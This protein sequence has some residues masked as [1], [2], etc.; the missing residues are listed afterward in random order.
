MLSSECSMGC[1]VSDIKSCFLC[2][3][4][5]DPDNEWESNP[6]NTC[7]SC[8]TDHAMYTGQE[9]KDLLNA[10]LCSGIIGFEDI[11]EA[12]HGI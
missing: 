4:Y 6:D 5:E 3:S 8:G 10:L 9:A 12:V 11:E 2:G 1:K 7:R